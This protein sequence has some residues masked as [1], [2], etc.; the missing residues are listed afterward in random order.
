MKALLNYATTEYECSSFIPILCR[1]CESE[2]GLRVT[3]PP[4]VVNQQ[5]SD[6][7]SH[8]PPPSF[9]V[10]GDMLRERKRVMTI[11][12]VSLKAD[13][14]A[15]TANLLR[16]INMLASLGIELTIH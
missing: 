10:Y 14:L 7:L 11:A 8:P 15:E 6:E 5:P 3:P 4:N 12:I 13:L 9:F 2:I 1:G 16:E